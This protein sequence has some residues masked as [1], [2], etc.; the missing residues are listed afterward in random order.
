[1]IF[2]IKSVNGVYKAK[3]VVKGRKVEAEGVTFMDALNA[4]TN[5]INSVKNA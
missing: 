5:I 3:G 1:M 4:I 2:T